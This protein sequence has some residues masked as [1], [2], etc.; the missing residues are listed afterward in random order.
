M[1]RLILS[2]LLLLVTGGRLLA[3]ATD[4]RLLADSLL[5]IAQQMAA[6]QDSLLIKKLDTNLVKTGTAP[7]AQSI[8]SWTFSGKVL[9]KN[10]NEGIPFATIFFPGTGMG[11][12]ADLDGNFEL[13]V[14]SLPVDTLYFQSVGYATFHQPVNRNQSAQNFTTEL[15]REAASLGEFVFHAGEDP[16]LALLKKVIRHKPQNNYDRLSGYRY[17]AYNKLEVDL[18]HLSKK[19][20]ESLPIPMIK[21]FSFIYKNVDSSEKTPFLPFYLTETLS[22]YYYQRSPK[23]TREFIK[24]SQ[25][26]GISNESITR[27]LGAMQQQLNVYDNYLLVFDKNFISPIADNAPFYYKYKIVDT[28]EAYGVDIYQV[29]FRPRR[30]GENCFFGDFWVADSSYAL[31]RI[32]LELPKEANINF[33]N[34]VSLYQEFKPLGDTLWFLVKDKFISDFTLPY[35]ARLPGFIGRKTTTYQDIH[36]GDS[37]TQSVLGNPKWK[38]NV[39]VAE[40]ARRKNEDYWQSHRHDSLSR[41]EKAIYGMIDTLESLPSF[42]RFKNLMKFVITGNIEAGPLEIGPY[43]YL[44][45]RNPVEGNRFRFTLG[46]TPKLF[47]DAYLNGYLAY[48]DKDREFKYQL[49]ALWLLNRTPRSYLYAQHTHDLNR[50]PGNDAQLSDDNI[51]SNIARKPGIPYKLAMEDLSRVEYFREYHSGFSHLLYAQYR[52]FQPYAP[53]PATGIFFNDEG[54]PQTAMTSNEAGVKL[55]YAWREKFV[56]G[57]YYRYSLGSR[58]PIVALTAGAGFKGFLDGHYDYQRLVLTIH[59]EA[60]IANLGKLSY[61]FFGGKIFG[62]VPYPLLEVH[63]GNEYY[64]YNKT[65]FSMMNE[66]EFISDQWAGCF[67]EHNFTGVF[68]YIPLLK[69][70]K[71]RQFWTAKGVIGSLSPANEALNLNKGFPFRTLAGNPYLELGTGISNI[72]QLFR[73]DFVWRVTPRPLPEEKKERYFGVFGSVQFNF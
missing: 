20:F 45:S 62:T 61:A 4:E 30:P 22:D 18:Q 65:S 39:I 3:Q 12:A 46:T 15:I 54:A 55:R 63:R 27:Y 57:N 47:K 19:Q 52:R 41:N 10:T 16:A 60:K 5:R 70:A 35:G 37:T 32:T 6:T 14:D 25:V 7:Q 42:Q 51:F 56:A 66:Y 36:I 38:E 11:T 13:K 2:V 64:Y 33:V 17:E 34:R 59:D 44:Y 68:K 49:S 40:D 31:Q 8:T 1:F 28:Q 71:L 24:A 26:K 53:L 50:R 23:K 72:L 29:S 43:Y 73:V 21:K 58:Y 48:G 67:L 69:K 9:D